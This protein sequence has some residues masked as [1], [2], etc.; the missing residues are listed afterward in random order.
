MIKKILLALTLAMAVSC[1]DSPAVD[2]FRAFTDGDRDLITD[3]QSLSNG[4][5]LDDLLVAI[6]D[7]CKDKHE[8][9]LIK[10]SGH[11]A[12][13]PWVQNRIDWGSKGCR[14]ISIGGL[15]VFG[16]PKSI[17]LGFH[18]EGVVVWKYEEEVREQ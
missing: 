13:L 12:G 14:Y 5:T 10:G 7:P 6:P 4:A 3:T 2:K 1:G 9:T 17:I 11:F 16:N 8:I 18:S 15:E